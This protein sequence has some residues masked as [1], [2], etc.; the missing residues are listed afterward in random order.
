MWR[1]LLVDALFG[2]W[3]AL[4]YALVHGWHLLSMSA[5]YGGPGSAGYVENTLGEMIAVFLAVVDWQLWRRK[6]VMLVGF[7]VPT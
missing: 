7:G 4:R 3:L 2:A 6:L 1:C 5:S